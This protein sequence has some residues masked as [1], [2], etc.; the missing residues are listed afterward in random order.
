MHEMTS[1]ENSRTRVGVVGIGLMGHGMAGS[2][3][4]AGFS[5]GVYNRNPEKCLPLQQRGAAVFE[6]PAQLAEMSDFVIVML[7]DD[8]AVGQ[9]CSGDQGL[10]AGGRSGLIV[11]NSSTVLPA[12]NQKLAARF[13]EREITLLDAPVTGSR[14]QAESGQLYFLV[15]GPESA[16]QAALPLFAA[17]GKGQIHLGPVGSGAC[18]KLGN[19]L[20]GF[21]N[22]CGIAEALELTSRFGLDPARFLEA[23]SHS[24]GRSAFSEGKGPKIL[25]EDWSPDFALQLAAKDLRLARTL[26]DELQ[27]QSPI[28]HQAEEVF[29][30]ASNMYGDRDVCSLVEWYR[31]SAK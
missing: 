3:L 9:V 31:R 5:V 12:T 29:A 2:L 17:M 10:L 13:A 26:A 4:N 22:L 18:A 19:N 25:R 7:S 6:T 16:F 11:M 27:Q 28:L 21:I 8:A 30:R 23:V 20:M 24:G 15:G 14:P 1:V